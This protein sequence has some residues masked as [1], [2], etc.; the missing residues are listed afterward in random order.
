[1]KNERDMTNNSSFTSIENDEHVERIKQ[2]YDEFYT[3]IRGYIRRNKGLLS[4]ELAVERLRNDL[5]ERYPEYDEKRVNRLIDFFTGN[6]PS[7]YY[8]ANKN[9]KEEL[10]KKEK[11]KEVALKENQKGKGGKKGKKTKSE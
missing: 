11:E 2:A 9:I 5:M 6:D 1:M 7:I 8:D 4:F 10:K 3:A